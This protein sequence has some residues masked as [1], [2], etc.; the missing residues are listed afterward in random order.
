MHI[1]AAFTEPFVDDLVADPEPTRLT[2]VACSRPAVPAQLVAGPRTVVLA[3]DAPAQVSTAPASWPRP[4]GCRFLAEPSSNARSGRCGIAGYRLLLDTALGERIERVLVFGH[5]T[6]SRPV[7]R[8]L[9][10]RDIELV[11]V[12]PSAS[13]PIR[14]AASQ[15]CDDV[16]LAPGDDDWLNEWRLVDRELPTDPSSAGRRAAGRGG[17]VLTGQSVADAVV[18]SAPQN[19]VFGA[20]SLIRNADL[21]PIADPIRD[22]PPTICWANRGLS[23]ID[24]VI[25]TAAGTALATARPATVLIGDLGFLHDAGSPHIPAGQPVPDLARGR[26]RRR[27]QHLRHARGR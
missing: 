15:V 27:W 4:P 6:L 19:L 17:G 13:W 11:V 24:G 8:L 12:S 25:S 14:W 22:D 5:P 10:R 3:G 21:S 18:A 16:E 1:N 20:S 23:G 7:H 2:S 9:S 26:R